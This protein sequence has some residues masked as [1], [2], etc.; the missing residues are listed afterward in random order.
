MMNGDRESPSRR[1][2]V[3]RRRPPSSLLIARPSRVDFF[4][5][6]S[7]PPR[8]SSSHASAC[9]AAR[10]LFQE[11]LMSIKQIRQRLE[12]IFLNRQ[13]ELADLLVPDPVPCTAPANLVIVYPGFLD[14]LKNIAS[15]LKPHIES[16]LT[17]KRDHA[18]L[19]AV[20][21]YRHRKKSYEEQIE[22]V[23][24]KVGGFEVGVAVFNEIR[25][26]G[27]KTGKFQPYVDNSDLVNADVWSDDVPGA[28]ATGMPL[29]I[30]NK[31][32]N[33]S[34]MG[35]GS[36]VNIDYSQ[37]L[38]GVF[39]NAPRGANVPTGP[40][41]ADDEVLIH[42]LV[43]AGRQ[44]N[45]LRYGMPVSGDYDNEEEYLAVVVANIYLSNKKLTRFRANHTGHDALK[46]PDHFLDSKASNLDPRTLLERLYLSQRT[47]YDALAALNDKITPFNPVRTYE[48]EMKAKKK[49]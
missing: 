9:E 38:W 16:E 37:D 2:P 39:S 30:K 1:L 19:R 34:G 43:H 28:N 33:G 44:M 42:E 48:A 31:Q 41:S 12:D 29:Y 20:D 8:R 27:K 18:L 6:T 49:H 5:V 26:A 10:F 22:K 13:K 23:L 15:D 4:P 36:D 14:W 46:D 17:A 40:A 25:K 3:D 24:G 32:I 45:G 47:L 11:E 21:K 7:G 35:T